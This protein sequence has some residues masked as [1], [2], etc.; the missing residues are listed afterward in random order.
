MCKEKCIPY[1]EKYGSYSFDP[2]RFSYIE[3]NHSESFDMKESAHEECYNYEANL[4]KRKKSGSVNAFYCVCGKRIHQLMLVY[5]T[6]DEDKIFMIGNECI[7]HIFPEDS[8]IYDKAVYTYC[9]VCD[10]KIKI[11][12]EKQHLESYK[13]IQNVKIHKHNMR[14]AKCNDLIP[15]SKYKLKCIKCF[16]SDKLKKRQCIRC[17][18]YNIKES[19]KFK[20]CFHCNKK[21]K[22]D[23]PFNNIYELPIF[24]RLKELKESEHQYIKD[25]ANHIFN[26]AIKAYN[27][28]ESEEWEKSI[29]GWFEDIKDMLN[30]EPNIKLHDNIPKWKNEYYKRINEPI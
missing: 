21:I 5:D 4:K 29:N 12:S 14:C 7:K 19:S 11:A 8:E 20:K 17:K 10:C 1:I 30:Y 16:V 24:R 9:T 22:K 13:H 28:D 6:R 27:D 15:K 26:K 23:G 2:S 18:K 3:Y 25:K